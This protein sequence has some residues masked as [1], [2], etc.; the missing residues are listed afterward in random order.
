VE[1]VGAIFAASGE[2]AVALCVSK[3]A[4]GYHFDDANGLTAH[5]LP[6]NLP[7]FS[8]KMAVFIDR[9][10]SARQLLLSGHRSTG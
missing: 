6:E 4:P 8:I 1:V 2:P 9:F 7:L 5:R 10:V 3:R